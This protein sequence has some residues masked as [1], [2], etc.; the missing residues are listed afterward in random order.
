MERRGRVLFQQKRQGLFEAS[1]VGQ[2]VP[3]AREALET[4]NR[5]CVQHAGLQHAV[6][7]FSFIN[8]GVLRAVALY[9]R[10]AQALQNPQL[11]FVWPQCIQAV[12]AGSKALQRFTRQAENQIGVQMR[13]G[14]LGEPVQIGFGPGVVLS[15]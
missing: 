2:Q 9:R 11:D 8:H 4:L 7:R 14:R 12:K 5:V 10:A 1:R 6:G 3:I 15:P 13:V